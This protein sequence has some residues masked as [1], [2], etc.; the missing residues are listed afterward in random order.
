MNAEDLARE[1]VSRLNR[2]LRWAV[3]DAEIQEAGLAINRY[4][5]ALVVQ[6]LR[7]DV[8]RRIAYHAPGF[9]LSSELRLRRR[10]AELRAVLIAAR[11]ALQA[12]GATPGEPI[13]NAIG[14]ILQQTDPDL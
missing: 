13:M 1:I 2:D 11:N 8:V 12:R 3:D 9:A 4:V 10:A 5:Q 6:A 7:P 14:T